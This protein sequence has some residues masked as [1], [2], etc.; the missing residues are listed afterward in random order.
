MVLEQAEVQP[1]IWLPTF[2]QYDFVGRK[3]L[4][5]FEIHE[6]REES[7]YQR[8]GPPN[9]ALIAIR[10]ELSQNTPTR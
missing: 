3:F 4:F 8:I 1:G 7:R 9:E 6:R 5:V 2:Y 10:R